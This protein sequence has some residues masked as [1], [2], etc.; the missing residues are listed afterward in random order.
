MLVKLS[1]TG[2]KEVKQNSLRT[3]SRSWS[4]WQSIISE[5]HRSPSPSLSYSVREHARTHACTHAHTRTHC[6]LLVPLLYQDHPSY[7]Q[8]PGTCCQTSLHNIEEMNGWPCSHSR[9]DPSQRQSLF[10]QPEAVSP[11]ARTPCPRASL[12]T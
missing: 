8:S 12:C 5:P 4:Q 9:T 7:T 11:R 10:L 3:I 1:L 6:S 2:P